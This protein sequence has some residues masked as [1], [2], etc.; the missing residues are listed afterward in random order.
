[1]GEQKVVDIILITLVLIGISC[2]WTDFLTSRINVYNSNEE[3]TDG[4]DRDKTLKNC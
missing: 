1:M 2:V 3:R 4:E